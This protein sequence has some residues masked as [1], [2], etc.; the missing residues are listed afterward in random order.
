MC[1]ALLLL[2]MWPVRLWSLG[3]ATTWQT[4]CCT[5]VSTLVHC[6]G[7]ECTR[8]QIHGECEWNCG[9]GTYADGSSTGYFI[10]AVLSVVKT[11]DLMLLLVLLP[12]TAMSAACFTVPCRLLCHA[13]PVQVVLSLCSTCRRP[14]RG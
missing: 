12:S 2:V 14:P 5:L 11:G 10:C 6:E 1:W 7:S 13:V 4:W 9:D 8:G 3:R